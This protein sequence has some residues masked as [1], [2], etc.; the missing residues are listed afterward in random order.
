GFLLR[1]SDPGTQPNS[2]L[3]PPTAGTP[4]AG[5]QSSS[6]AV[7]G[8]GLA[9]R[10]RRLAENWEAGRQPS[11]SEPER[12]EKL[13][14]RPRGVRIPRPARAAGARVQVAARVGVALGAL[15][16]VD[17]GREDIV[18][19]GDGEEVAARVDDG[20]GGVERRGDDE[21]VVVDG[22]GREDL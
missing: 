8:A 19:D 22:A 12:G 9:S 1:N 14:I 17:V 4:F 16:Q 2:Q 15:V 13:F 10:G 11:P 5:R 20:G 21:D 7:E 18:H 3:T 6:S